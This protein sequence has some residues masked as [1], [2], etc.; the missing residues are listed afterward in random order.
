[1]AISQR[2][3][4]EVLGV[5][6]DADQK[7]IKNA[8]RQLALKFHP[9]R[10]KAA[11][12]EEKFK[13]IAEAYAILSD[14]EKRAKYDSGG[15]A[16]VADFS[17]E[18][19]FGGMNFD[20]IFGGM[21]FGFE[22]GGSDGEIFDRFFRHQRRG[23]EKGRDIEVQVRVSL[24]AINNGSEQ[25]IRLNH[26]ITCS[27]CQGS[28][29]EAGSK[30]RK[31]EACGGTGQQVISKKTSKDKSQMVFQQISVCPTCH[32]QGIFID[33]PCK[34]CHG[35]GQLDKEES[36]KIKIPKGAEDG[37][38]L[39]IPGHGMPSPTTSGKPGD[40]YVIVTTEHDNRFQRSGADLWCT[41][42]I[43]VTDA[44]LGTQLDIPTLDKNI[45]VKVPPGTQQ[46]EILRLR[47]KG[48]PVMN[49]IGRGDLKIRIMINIPQK[50]TEKERE[51][52]EQLR[53]LN[54]EH[55]NHWWSKN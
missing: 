4:Y 48:L 24:D 35:T 53:Q 37:M 38:A 32:G 1:M 25:S 15:F 8:F 20:D 49:N 39:R 3:Y 31:C 55:K 17:A 47:G 2:D 30:P 36:L 46:D 33:K 19:L 13:E 16:G 27:A 7:A 10:N 44:V 28:G 6:R 43:N 12:A 50:I 23:P 42:A 21:D 51:L 22:F 41:R 5:A 26:P 54:K 18:D 45:T 40:L 11:D 29:A 14:P 34:K 9:D 52:Y